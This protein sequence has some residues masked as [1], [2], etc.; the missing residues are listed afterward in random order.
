MWLQPSNAEKQRHSGG[1]GII[2]SGGQE[3]V[4]P[5]K[6]NQTHPKGVVRQPG[7]RGHQAKGTKHQREKRLPRARLRS[8][9]DAVPR[10]GAAH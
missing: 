5:G 9:Q 1:S 3:A 2:P 7:H 8:H 4:T 10:A 6:G